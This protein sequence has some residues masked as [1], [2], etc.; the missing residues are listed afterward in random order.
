MT[1]MDKQDPYYP[2]RFWNHLGRAHFVARQYPEAIDAFKHLSAP[3]HT[4]HAFLAACAAQEGDE[5]AAKIHADEVLKQEPGF[6][7]SGYLSTLHYKHESDREHHQDGLVKAG[8][9]A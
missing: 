8:L 9:P 7:V 2:Q 3:D 4:H 1:F 6:T 5:A